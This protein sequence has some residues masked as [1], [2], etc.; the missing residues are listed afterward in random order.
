[1]II[2]KKHKNDTHYRFSI[3]IGNFDGIHLGHRFLLEKLKQCKKTEFDRLAVLTFHPHPVKVI[4]PNK[5][6]KNLI[7]FRTKFRLLKKK[8]FGCFICYTV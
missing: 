5:W 6:K 8:W 3:A 1:M 4:Y 7:R 2:K